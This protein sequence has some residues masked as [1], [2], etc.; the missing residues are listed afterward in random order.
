VSAVIVDTSAVLALFDEAYEEHSRLASLVANPAVPLVVSPLVAAEA[1]YMLLS[2]LGDRA[3]RR[4]AGDIASEAYELAEWSAADHAAALSVMDRS[5]GPG[6]YVG[7]ADA[8]N[9]VLADTY[10][11]TRIMTLDQR[12]FRTLRPLWGADHFTILPYDA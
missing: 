10:R 3:A 7:V 12:H 4:F 5:A 6:D 2:R 11:T 8:A 1:D 9:V